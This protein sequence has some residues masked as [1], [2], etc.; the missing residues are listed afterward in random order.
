MPDTDATCAYF[1]LHKTVNKLPIP[2]G[3]GSVH[4][5]VT[6]E[7]VVRIG[8]YP[9]ALRDA[10]QQLR[11]GAAVSTHAGDRSRIAALIDAGADV[12]VIDSAQGSTPLA[13]QCIRWIKAQK[14][15][16][17]VIAGNVV[18]PMQAQP[19]VEAGADALRVG[20][21]SGS[22]CTT[23]GVLRI[24][25][26]QL[27]AVYH[28]ARFA[29]A[30][31]IPIIA[32][33]GIRN[34]GDML[35]AL[36]CGAATVMV[37]RL[38]AGCDETPAEEILDAAGQRQKRYRGMGSQSAIREGGRYRYGE[39]R[40]DHTMVAQGIEAEVP[41]QGSLDRL[42]PEL[43]AAIRK[44]LEYLGCATVHTLHESVNGGRVRFE[45]Q[46]HAAWAEGRPHDV[47]VLPPLSLRAPGSTL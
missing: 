27:T 42:L 36:A 10:N 39:S 41:P 8:Q 46:S 2:N 45:L 24:G 22:I 16:L 44:G 26:A 3:D 21:G 20:M 47:G 40:D 23:Q 33:G 5:L 38:I 9:N 17:P 28:V 7:D 11:V 35:A 32:D 15:D 14:P 12:L 6:R 18:T 31:R 29:K 13:V 19:L 37:G 34:S 43:A 4:A 25:R 30:S 1:R